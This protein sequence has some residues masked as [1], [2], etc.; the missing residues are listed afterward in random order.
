MP[1]SSQA[2][3]RTRVHDRWAEE[4]RWARRPLVSGLSGLTLEAPTRRDFTSPE[5][6]GVG[7]GLGRT[8]GSTHDP[9]VFS[10]SGRSASRRD[11]D[12]AFRIWSRSF[13]QE[14]DDRVEEETRRHAPAGLRR[15]PES[16]RR[17]AESLRRVAESLRRVP[18]SL[19]RVAESL[20]RVPDSLRRAAAGL[21]NAP[22]GLRSAAA[23]LRNAPAG[24]RGAA[25]G[26]R[27]AAAGLRN[28]PTGERREQ[29]RALSRSARPRSAGRAT[30]A[31]A[32]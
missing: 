9:G 4:R 18:E 21:R 27:R 2:S 12:A 10:E 3:G 11:A 25:A 5:T 1:D 22:A 16:L 32:P 6:G 26:L 31:R 8:P 29:A 19:R 24:L 7:S 28:A 17:V 20:R 30:R 15:T 23:G 14:R 13:F